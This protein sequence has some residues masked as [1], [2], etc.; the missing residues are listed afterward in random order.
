MCSH[1]DQGPG[2]GC[3]GFGRTVGDVVTLRIYDASGRPVGAH[4]SIS[5]DYGVRL[6]RDFCGSSGPLRAE[7]GRLAVFLRVQ[8]GYSLTCGSSPA[9][10][11][12]GRVQA[13]FAAAD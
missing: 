13:T 2:I 8:S 11:T 5:D 3:V 7:P 12:R 1:D 10:A 6:R 9:V 4:A